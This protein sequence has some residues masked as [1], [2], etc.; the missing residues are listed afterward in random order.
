MSACSDDTFVGPSLNSRMACLYMAVGR[1][2][3]WWPEKIRLLFLSAP[4]KSIHSKCLPHL[5]GPLPR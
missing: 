5:E 4:S 3:L 2:C 1:F